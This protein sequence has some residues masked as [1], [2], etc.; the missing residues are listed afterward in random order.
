MPRNF[1]RGFGKGIVTV[2]V[3]LTLNASCTKGYDPGNYLNDKFA[4]LTGQPAIA[5]WELKAVQV[6]NVID[7]SAKG[8]VKVYHPD[9]TFTDELGFTGYWTLATRDS[10]IEST[11]SSVNP[12]APFFNNRFKIE[13]LDKGSL[14]LIQLDSDKKIR[15]IYDAKK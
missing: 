15:L 7:S 9:G 2:L 11:R 12:N 3:A 5:N 14:Q 6:N 13:Q 4:L 10:L 1:P 8:T